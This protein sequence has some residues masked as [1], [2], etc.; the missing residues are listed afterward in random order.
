MS[1][2]DSRLRKIEGRQHV[3]DPTPPDPFAGRDDLV[4]TV[5]AKAY[6]AGTDRGEGPDDGAKTWNAL[7]ARLRAENL[8]WR[9]LDES[10]RARVREIAG[11]VI[12]RVGP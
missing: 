11:E 9:S 4:R 7:M 12:G 3:L 6:L 1:G 10:G 5:L 8:H 2:F